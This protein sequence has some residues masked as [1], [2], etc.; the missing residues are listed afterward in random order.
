MPD[1][2]TTVE[3]P[4]AEPTE[5]AAA[6]T[7]ERSKLTR[8]EQDARDKAAFLAAVADEKPAAEVE[9]PKAKAKPAP[10]AVD[11]EDDADDKIETADDEDDLDIDDD[12]VPEDDAQE[13]E[14]AG[15]DAELAKRLAK[16][17]RQE[18]RM[19][20]QHAARDREFEGERQRFIAEWEPRVKA[21]EAF[22]KIAK[23]DVVGILKA[24]G[25]TDDDFEYASKVL[26]GYT[27]A[28]AADPKNREAVAR[29]QKERMT[30]DE[31]DELKAWRAG[32]E[33]RRVKA[34]ADAASAKQID[35]FISRTSKAITD[36]HEHLHAHMEENP[37]ATKLRL[38][39]LA[40]KMAMKAGTLDVPP[41]KIV[42]A[43]EKKLASEA[44]LME[45][46][47]GKRTAKAPAAAA[48]PA[49][50]APAKAKAIT[51]VDKTA[52]SPVVEHKRTNGSLLP[53]REEMLEGLGK[54]QR[55]EIEPD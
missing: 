29:L 33:E 30:R 6:P 52:G 12:E 55:G 11:D 17:R 36:K 44:E 42:D 5:A 23:H 54:L 32:E 18:Q 19:R 8:A 14:D 13:R 31:L 45:R 39:R 46:I 37:K 53:S 16:V 24:K 34:E 49:K 26:Y 51:V 21:A 47:K 27:P 15:G 4:A 41:K 9:K 50:P 20:D 7:T 10:V 2:E 43:L 35:A 1:L 40:Y 25:Y 48:A 22:H 3:A 28:A 38:D